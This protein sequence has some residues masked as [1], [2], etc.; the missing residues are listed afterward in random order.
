MIFFLYN[1]PD[2]QLFPGSDDSPSGVNPKLYVIFGSIGLMTSAFV[3]VI[4]LWFLKIR[5]NS[6]NDSTKKIFR[7]KGNVQNIDQDQTLYNQVDLLPYD[8]TF[9]ISRRRLQ[10]RQRIGV[11][12]FGTIYKASAQGFQ[13]DEEKTIVAAKVIKKHDDVEVRLNV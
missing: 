7:K 1:F 12:T 8:K 6:K 13:F 10:L 5:V 11:S 4:C 3:C 9:E 2:F